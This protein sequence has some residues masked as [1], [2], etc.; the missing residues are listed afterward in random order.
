LLGTKPSLA[1]AQIIGYI[2]HLKSKGIS[3]S[4][5]NSMLRAIMDFYT[6]NDVTLN[7]KKIARFMDEKKRGLRSEQDH[8]YSR[9][10]IAE[11]LTVCDERTKAIILLL[12]LTGMRIGAIPAQ[13]HHTRY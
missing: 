11:I 13:Q 7:P 6:M 8:A 2:V 5:I 12:T 1:E 9:E 4:P 3:Y 10:Q